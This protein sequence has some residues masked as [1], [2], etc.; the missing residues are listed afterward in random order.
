MKIEIGS[1][2]RIRKLQKAWPRPIRPNVVGQNG[3]VVKIIGDPK[4]LDLAP[5]IVVAPVSDPDRP[6]GCTEVELEDGDVISTM[7]DLVRVVA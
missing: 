6:I 7:G 5:V 1:L 2:V 4:R 3:F